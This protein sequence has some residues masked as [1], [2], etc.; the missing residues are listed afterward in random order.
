MNAV[1][2]ASP[3]PTP[4]PSRVVELTM[5][6]RNSVRGSTGSAARSSMNTNAIS[7]AAPSPKTVNEAGEFHAQASPPS[8]TP[9]IS[10][11]MA[12]VSVAAPP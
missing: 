7:S 6:R 9:S 10:S 1:S 12:P 11:V 3:I 4:R 5:R 2:P 8:R